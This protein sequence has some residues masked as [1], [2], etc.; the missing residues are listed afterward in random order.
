MACE[1]E[2]QK[3]TDLQDSLSLFREQCASGIKGACGKIAGV[4]AQ[5]KQAQAAL[6]D[7]VKNTGGGGGGTGGGGTGGGGTGGGGTGGGGTGGGGTGGGGTGGK[8]DALQER[9]TNL[10]DALSLA[11]EQC[12][13]GLKNAC[14][15]IPGLEAQLT[16]AEADLRDCLNPRTVT[17][18]RPGDNI[19]NPYTIAIIANP[20][21]ERPLG[22]G[23]FVV[24]PIMAN[25]ALFNTTVNYIVTNLFD[26]LADQRETFLNSPGIGPKIRVLS[27]VILNLP[28][29]TNTAMIGEEKTTNIIDPRPAAIQSVLGLFHLPADVIYAVTASPTHTRS[30]SIPGT[31]DDSRGGVSFTLDGAT[32]NH[33][34]FSTIPGTVALSTTANSLTALHEFGHAASSVNNGFVDDLYMKITSLPPKAINVKTARPIP[35]NFANYNGTTMLSDKNRDGLGYPKD[36]LNYDCELLDASL[37]AVMDNY[38]QAGDGVP[39]HCRHD[40]ITRQF[41]IDRITAK[42][43]RKNP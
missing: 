16:K 43:S 11:R 39:V 35:V 3:V 6:A 41:L 10:E 14:G 8:C 30:S 37:P 9:V 2:Q 15:L 22:S 4:E 12:A 40:R 36:W 32:L 28:P 19:P 17:V 20:A 26:G 38:F 18:I 21:L 31:D 1:K 5:L 7:C 42:L 13:A 33:R 27:L 29:D 23:N 24:D 25:L 34:F